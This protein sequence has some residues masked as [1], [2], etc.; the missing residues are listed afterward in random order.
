MAEA[1]VATGAE[2]IAAAFHGPRAALMPYLMGGFPSLAESLA[3]GQAYAEYADLVELGVPFSDPLADGPAIQAAGQRALEQGATFERV[4]DEVAAP[5]ARDVPVVLMCYANP[6]LARGLQRAVDAIAGR[7][8]SGLI[9]PDMPAA[10]AAELRA[11]CDEAGVALVPLVA[12]TTPPEEVRQIAEAAR[13]FVYV[14]SVTGVTGE[15]ASLPPALG[16]VVAR[17][18]EAADV[19]VAV[20]FGVGTPDQVAAVGEIAD[21]VIVGSRLV[22]GVL[23]APTHDDAL[24]D[25]RGFLAES[26]SRLR[27]SPG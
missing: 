19:P 13:G 25:V 4:L 8:V 23:D 27:R 7:G 5:L 16:E 14:V 17:V 1:E 26:A 18:R 20:G 24:T 9:V 15:R 21:G 12:P 2:R 3:V 22:R 6:L 10:E 11:H